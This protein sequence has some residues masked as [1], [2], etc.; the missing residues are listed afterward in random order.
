[1]AVVLFGYSFGGFVAQGMLDSVPDDCRVIGVVLASTWCP[2]VQPLFP[3]GHAKH[4]HVKK[5]SSLHA[6]KNIP[7]MFVRV[8]LSTEQRKV[9]ENIIQ[10][11]MPAEEL[12]A[13]LVAAADFVTQYVCSTCILNVP[14]LFLHG[15][16][17]GIFSIHDVKRSHDS[18]PKSRLVIIPD[19]RHNFI[20]THAQDTMDTVFGW[21]GNLTC[22]ADGDVTCPGFLTAASCTATG[23]NAWLPWCVATCVTAVFVV[24]FVILYAVAVAKRSRK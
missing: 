18:L 22:D 20:V 13:Q 10:S 2:V 23:Y 17:D 24:V 5:I 4:S 7:P 19:G 16:K 15:A 14:V 3:P 8:M 12:D 6:I 1:M 9:L 21:I 11:Q